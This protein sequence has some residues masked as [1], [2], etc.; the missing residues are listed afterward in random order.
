MNNLP[1]IKIGLIAGKASN[2]HW[3]L[4]Y[5]CLHQCHCAL[6]C[7]AMLLRE[8]F[9]PF[10]HCCTQS[11]NSKQIS[12][13]LQHCSCIWHTTCGTGIHCIVTNRTKIESMLS[14]QHWLGKGTRFNQVLPT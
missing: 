3:H 2:S 12:R 1:T 5:Q 11:I 13:L 4:F 14:N 8:S 9:C 10:P 7:S 6:C